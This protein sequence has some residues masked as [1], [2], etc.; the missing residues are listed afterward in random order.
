MSLKRF[1]VALAGVAAIA[2]VL[3][4]P[5]SGSSASTGS[6]HY[7]IDCAVSPLCLEVNSPSEIFKSTKYV[8]HDEPSALFYSN[9][10]GSG[11]S[12]LYRLTLPTD[13]PPS[14][15]NSFNFELHPAFWFG[16]AL[17]NVQSY[18]EQVSTCTPNS[19]TNIKNSPDQTSPNWLG[20][21]AGTAFLELQ[22][23]PPGWAALPAGISCNGTQ[24]CVA[25][26]IWS[27]AEDPIAG[28]TINDSCG[29][30]IG[31]AEY[32]N[33]AFLTLSGVP[34]APANPVDA[35]V[36]T[37]TP[38]PSTDLF[39]NSGDQL[40]VDIHDTSQG[41]T[42]IVHDLTSGQTGS[43]TA[44]AANSFGMVKYAPNPSTECTN[45][46][47]DFHP[48]YSTS[49]PDTRVI[50]AAHTYN[51]AFADEIGHFDFCT[52]VSQGGYCYGNEGSGANS[53]K[54]DGDDAGCF[55]AN[56]STLVRVAGCAAT[57]TGFDGTPYEPVWPDGNPSHP[58]AILF[59]S[60]LTNG[61]NYSQVAFEADMPRIEAADFGG[62]CNRTT[63]NGCT[64]PPLTD[65]ANASGVRPPADFYPFF[66]TQQ[67]A[68]QCTWAIGN[69]NPGVTTN[70]FGRVSQYGQLLFQ[71]YLRF[72]G[73]GTSRY[74]TDNYRQ[75]LSG[76]PCQIS[77]GGS[78]D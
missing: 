8:G 49:S 6:S 62:L 1:R 76:N 56:Q 52:G 23:Y 34:H 25:M 70:D 58:T 33:L 47:Y 54:T 64:N 5:V 14:K 29:A 66:S 78:D 42:T 67:T 65:D 10:A 68:G 40:T 11:N 3:A 75:V 16:M 30:V 48:M 9:R 4:G 43:M 46:P 17:C 31:G 26:L 15:S 69:D 35:T 44:S 22:F 27:L 77:S 45:I 2:A 21:H 37:F 12:S 13:P 53:E 28:T 20:H 71:Y 55:N 39:M 60:P 18:P 32:P 59:S 63:G 41:F 73:G 72:G 51:V 61:R 38:N 19:D 36:S 57:N 74:I 7:S 24:W 50:W